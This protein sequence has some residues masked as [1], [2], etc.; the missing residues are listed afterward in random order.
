MFPCFPCF[1]FFLLLIWTHG[2]EGHYSAEVL[3]ESETQSPSATGALAWSLEWFGKNL[4]SVPGFNDRC[5]SLMWKCQKVR[6][7]LVHSVMG[8]RRD[9]IAEGASCISTKQWGH[10]TKFSLWL[11]GKHWGVRAWVKEGLLAGVRWP[12]WKGC[13]GRLPPQERVSIGI[14]A[15]SEGTD[16]T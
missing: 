11:K 6:D 7:E 15:H 12:Q 5:L 14:T 16:P 9:G 3:W 10:R 2:W 1:L 4:P 8:R 13:V